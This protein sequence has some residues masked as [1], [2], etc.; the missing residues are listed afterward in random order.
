MV[1]GSK[2]WNVLG[3]CSHRDIKGRNK[4]LF[5][6]SGY[7]ER[8]KLRSTQVSSVGTLLKLS[9]T[10]IYDVNLII[11]LQSEDSRDC[12]FSI[13]YSKLGC[14]CGLLNMSTRVRITKTLKLSEPV[15]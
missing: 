2:P 3:S 7:F 10:I 8:S 13:T 12:F 9:R 1:E 15:A 6:N 14:H 5:Y 11:S 4:E